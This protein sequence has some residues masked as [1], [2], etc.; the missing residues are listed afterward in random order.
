MSIQ[1][2]VNSLNYSIRGGVARHT[3]EL[4]KALS[5]IGCKVIVSCMKI[6]ENLHL[7]LKGKMLLPTLRKPVLDILSFN[8]CLLRKSAHF[9]VNI[10][11]SQGPYGFIF[12]LTKRKPFVVTVHGV[13]SQILRDFPSLRYH[14]SPNAML[15]F[16]RIVINKADKI[17]AVSDDIRKRI[18]SKYK[19]AEA[20]ITVIPNG[21]D[22]ER[23]NPYLDTQSIF[24][25]YNIRRPLI[26]CVN[27]LE[28]ARNVHSLIFMMK[29]VT[30]EIP[31]ATLIIAG[32]GP[33]KRKLEELRNHYGLT[34][35]ILFVG[36][37]TDEQLPYYYAA[38]DLYVLPLAPGLSALEAM[39]SG[40]AVVCLSKG[41]FAVEGLIN[42][43]NIIITQNNA[44][45]TSNV[46]NLLQDEAKRREIG[47]A[48][49]KT[50]VENYAWAKIAQKTI[51]LYKELL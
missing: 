3:Y 6:P 38:A 30:R 44:S 12:A 26:L 9:E 45:F 28:T 51:E 5:K 11:H 24:T 36:A 22:V 39:A 19:V 20:K 27:R 37:L 8:L 33:L 18:L 47:L 31:S 4:S 40:K 16:E 32:D 17:I 7:D 10:I 13:I 50:V 49:R 43:K 21:V 2:I 23:F 41:D 15:L 48:A 29:E 14:L 34:K 1:M 35:N 42:G 25:K 46:I